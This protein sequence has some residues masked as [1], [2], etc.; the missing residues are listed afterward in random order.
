MDSILNKR[1]QLLFDKNHAIFHQVNKEGFI[2]YI[3]S[4]FAYHMTFSFISID[5]LIICY[6]LATNILI[7]D[8]LGLLLIYR[9]DSLKILSSVL[10]VSQC[11][12]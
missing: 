2:V 7:K 10:K 5:L 8:F 6:S 3:H 9:V 12:P 1:F 4:S 11:L